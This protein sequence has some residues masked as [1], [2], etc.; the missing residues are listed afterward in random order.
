MLPAGYT[1]RP[2]STADQAAVTLSTTQAALE[3]A[4]R[5]LLD[6]PSSPRWHEVQQHLAAAA[7]LLSGKMAPTAASALDAVSRIMPT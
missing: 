5:L 4:D 6:D 7:L 3:R 2:L 1:P